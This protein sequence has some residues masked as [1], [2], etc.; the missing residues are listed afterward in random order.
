MGK[1]I[2]KADAVDILFRLMEEEN[3]NCY[4]FCNLNRHSQ[5]NTAKRKHESQIFKSALQMA[6]N[7]ICKL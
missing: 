5:V 7:E 1:T 3:D 4:A 6:L 2:E